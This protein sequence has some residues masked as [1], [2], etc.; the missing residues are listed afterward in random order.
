MLHYGHISY[1]KDAK[2]LGGRLIVILNN[3][4]Q[5]KKK[6]GYVPIDQNER[7]KIIESIKYVDEVVIA[8]DDDS[9]VAKTLE[10]IKPDIFCNSGDRNSSNASSQEVDMCNKIG[11]CVVYLV[12]PKV[13]SSSKIIEI[14]RGAK[15]V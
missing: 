4:I 1:F 8:L 14:I 10:L 6:Y 15:D 13:N 7:K 9:S 3:D 11:C 2:A 5:L 12:S